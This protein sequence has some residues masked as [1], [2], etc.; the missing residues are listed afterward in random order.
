MA[1]MLL[2]AGSAFAQNYLNVGYGLPTLRYN[3]GEKLGTEKVDYNKFFAGYSHNFELASEFGLEA[4]LNFVFGLDK[5]KEKDLDAVV[6]NT[7]F[8]FEAPVLANYTFV[9]ESDIKFKAFAG[10]VFHCGLSDKTTSIV[11]GGKTW[12]IDN[13]K[14]G[15]LNRFNVSAAIAVAAEFS[16]RYRVKIGYDF[17]LTDVDKNDNIKLHE[18]CISFTLGYIF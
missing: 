1:A 11:S 9:N 4:G 15:D 7:S 2:V 14:D 12:D 10:P 3:Y 6:R 13:Y 17:G 18:N 16:N 5:D 8:L